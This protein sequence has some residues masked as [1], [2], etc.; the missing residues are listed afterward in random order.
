MKFRCLTLC[1]GEVCTDDN[2]ADVNDNDD[3]AQWTMHELYKGSLVHKPNEPKTLGT[4]MKRATA[5]KI[6]LVKSNVSNM[7]Y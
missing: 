7:M 5:Q 2:N 3:N 4:N 6:F 1:Q